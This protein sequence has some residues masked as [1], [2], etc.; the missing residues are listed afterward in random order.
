MR[1]GAHWPNSGGSTMVGNSGASVCVRSITLIEPSA[2]RL[3]ERS[4]IESHG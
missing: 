1:N 3:R 4:K 2:I